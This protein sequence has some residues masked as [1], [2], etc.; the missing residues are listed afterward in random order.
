MASAR[1]MRK[2]FAPR[3]L[4]QSLQR[5]CHLV[6]PPWRPLDY[7][8]GL[9]H[10]KQHRARQTHPFAPGC[11]HCSGFPTTSLQDLKIGIWEE[12]PEDNAA[13]EKHCVRSCWALSLKPFVTPI[14]SCGR[15]GATTRK[16]EKLRLPV[17]GD[18]T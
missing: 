10:I 17:T 7:N 16:F 3:F 15:I 11:D 8:G 13:V 12:I 9:V 1:H 5:S 2:R 4:K 6:L 14:R 18:E